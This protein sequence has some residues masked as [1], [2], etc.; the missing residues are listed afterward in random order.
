MSTRPVRWLVSLACA[1]ALAGCSSDPSVGG[2]DLAAGADLGAAPDLAGC[3][4]SAC[5]GP[6]Q[7]CEGGRCLSDCRRSGSG[8]CAADKVCD[9]LS[10]QCLAADTACLVP[11]RYDACPGAAA[12]RCG[13][14]S[15]CAPDGTCV[16][17]GTCAGALGCDGDGRCRAAG[18]S[19]ERPAASCLP[20]PLAKM[21]Q[22]PFNQSPWDVKFDR[23]CNAYAV[24]V[25]SGGD[26]LRQLAPDG[27]VVSTPGQGNLDMVEV[28]PAPLVPGA[29][30][31]G[32]VALSYNQGGPGLTLLNRAA[33]QPDL[34][35]VV[36]VTVSGGS[37]P[38]DARYEGGVLGLTYGG[39]GKLYAGNINVPGE[40]A[41][42]DLE[43]RQV[44]SLLLLP[45]RVH[46]AT[47]YD[48]RSLLVALA[49]GSLVLVD[50]V[51][52]TSAPFARLDGAVA[53]LQRDRFSGA[54]YAAVAGPPR[55]LVLSGDGAR[56]A[57]FQDQPRLGRLAL[58]PDGS[59]YHVGSTV[60]GVATFTR[61]RLPTTR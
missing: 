41:Q 7:L 40:V 4:P 60:D 15:A 17:D 18:C 27:T 11:D 21:N 42:V 51:A 55:V 50:V 10:G 19:C 32:N 29:Q 8:A 23:L 53:S 38:I 31:P 36:T 9:F 57:V 49:D 56:R 2:E 20:A 6:G 24:T 16:L 22:A 5:N 47:A 43:K 37:G 30:G 12:Q 58:A 26:F 46:A 54:I 34:I 33:A 3:D 48:S 1:L 52:R 28:A 39:D 59:L 14:G 13:P 25:I 44:V 61:W 45:Q 35:R